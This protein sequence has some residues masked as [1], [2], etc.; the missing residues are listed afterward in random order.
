[1]EYKL[2]ITREYID[3]GVYRLFNIERKDGQL[4]DIYSDL[5]NAI[6]FIKIDKIPEFLKNMVLERSMQISEYTFIHFGEILEDNI[7]QV[8]ADCV[9]IFL[10][11]AKTIVQKRFFF[12]LTLELAQKSLMAVNLFNL[13]DSEFV[14]EKWVESIKLVIPEI[15]EKIKSYV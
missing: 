12:E 7:I 1:M 3:K 14:D 15:E 5:I 4:I 2:I 11:D 6:A 9:G 8:P 13:R 10:M